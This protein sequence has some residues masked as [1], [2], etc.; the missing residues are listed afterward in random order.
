[1]GILGPDWGIDDRRNE[2][3]LIVDYDTLFTLREYQKDAVR[4]F[5]GT[6]IGVC[7]APTGTGKTY[8]MLE[9]IKKHL[10]NTLILVDTYELAEQFKKRLTELTTLQEIG[11]VG[12]GKKKA[13][14]P[15]TIALLQTMRN[16]SDE[17]FTMVNKMFGQILYDET[18]GCPATTYYE[19]L[20]KLNMKRKYGFSAT[21]YRDD[22]LTK[23]IFWATGPKIHTVS[24]KEADDH[25]LKPE[26]EILKTKFTWPL[27]QSTDY[28]FCVSDLSIDK[29]RNKIIT[30]HY[31]K[32]EE[33]HTK[34]TVFLCTLRSQ[35]YKLWSD[36][37]KKG[38]VLISP[39]DK[40]TKLKLAQDL[41]LTKVQIKAFNKFSGKKNRNAV[42]QGLRDGTITQVFSTY[43]LFNKGIDI[44]RLEI[45]Y[46]CGPFRSR[47]R[48]LQSR[49]R[50]VRKRVDG[51]DKSP[52]II[53]V[54]DERIGLF[55][56]QGMTVHRA[57]RKANQ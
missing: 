18:H 50:I 10:Q 29:D 11:Y 20:G 15:V 17:E 34:Q 48:I 7:E 14:K 45:L 6:T 37:G 5:T 12:G 47:T 3:P 16:L 43:A 55:K 30:D 9:L 33:F 57:L 2:S 32:H 27:I 39:L 38:G 22:G 19:L 35:I 51:V 53:H 21:P 49:G 8:I 52:K 54:F 28:S 46:M 42:I 31:N 23:V 24:N 4:S 1:L 40:D 13:W 44:D 26:L 36:L 56:N 41:K 25:V